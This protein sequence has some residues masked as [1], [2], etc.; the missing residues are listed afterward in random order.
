MFQALEKEEKEKVDLIVYEISD[1]F[2]T[3]LDKL[4]DKYK[5]D[6]WINHHLFSLEYC[7]LNKCSLAYL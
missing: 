2:R 1:M 5:R 7:C 4:R 3:D 6:L